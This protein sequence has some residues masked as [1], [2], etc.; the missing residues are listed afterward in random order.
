MLTVTSL[1]I[2]LCLSVVPSRRL[3][4]VERRGKIARRGSYSMAAL[5]AY[6]NQDIDCNTTS[7]CDSG[8]ATANLKCSTWTLGGSIGAEWEIVEDVL[9]IDGSFEPSGGK[10][11]CTTATTTKSCHWN[12]QKCHSLWTSTVLYV[13]HG[14]IRRR[15]NGGGDHTVWS[16]DWA[17]TSSTSYAHEGC[18]ATCDMTSYPG[19]LPVVSGAQG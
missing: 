11:E 7:L 1:S 17:T 18:A 5:L 6:N 13:D 3:D 19:P 15:C 4:E 8:V 9:T 10:T 12:D 14:Y 16:K 2:V